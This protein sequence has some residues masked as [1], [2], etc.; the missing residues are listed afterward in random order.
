MHCKSDVCI[1]SFAVSER[2]IDLLSYQF[3]YIAFILRS[4]H[5]HIRSSHKILSSVSL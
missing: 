5:I 3:K 1:C 2:S 4:P